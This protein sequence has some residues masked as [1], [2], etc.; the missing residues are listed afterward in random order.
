MDSLVQLWL[1][2]GWA[3]PL[4]ILLAVLLA[5][6]IFFDWCDNRA[7]RWRSVKRRRL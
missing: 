3:W 2:I 4:F 1:R 5:A 6:D 7:K